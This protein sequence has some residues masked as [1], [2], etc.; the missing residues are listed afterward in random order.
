M[1]G[2]YE[3]DEEWIKNFENMENE[4]D[5]FY[6]EK[7]K[8]IEIIYIYIDNNK[9]I[10]FIKKEDYDLN[11]EAKILKSNLIFLINDNKIM[12][13]KKYK[14]LNIL[15]YNFTIEP[16]EI[17]HEFRKLDIDISNNNNNNNNNKYLQNITAINDVLFNDTVELFTEL[18]TLYVI[19]ADEKNIKQT[20]K[21]IFF[22]NN[23]KNNNKNNNNKKM[24][25]TKRK[26]YKGF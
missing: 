13:E 22:N 18:N 12:C 19:Y 17:L 14:L 6:K 26:R 15:K 7:P 2:D 10:E 11:N 8:I 20:T 9:E 24:S 16:V 4:Y 21:K 3:I 1:D 23:N 5:I 25:K